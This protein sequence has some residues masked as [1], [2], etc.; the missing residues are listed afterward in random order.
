MKSAIRLLAGA[1]LAIVAPVLVGLSPVPIAAQAQEAGVPEASGAALLAPCSACH[2]PG[3]ASPGAIP[4]ID[5]LAPEEIGQMMHAF[6][7]GAVEGTVM[8]RI[9]RGYTD[10]EIDAIVAF[11]ASPDR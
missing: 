4:A 7:S 1:T 11:L 5:Q 10:A 6:R 3:G 2:G 8:N 9:A